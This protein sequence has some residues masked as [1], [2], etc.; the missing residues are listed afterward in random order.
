MTDLRGFL[1]MDSSGT[2]LCATDCWLVS[3]D[4][5]PEAVWD[6]MADDALSDSEAAEAGR[7]YGRKLASVVRLR[8]AL[9]G[10]S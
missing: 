7:Q 9:P 10:E 8:A 5:L 4:A 2:V 3:P 1:I 6:A